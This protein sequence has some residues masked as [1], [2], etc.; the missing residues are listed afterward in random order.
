M[1]YDVNRSHLCLILKGILHPYIQYR[2]CSSPPNIVSEGGWPNLRSKSKLTVQY[3]LY[4]L[5][6]I[7]VLF[8]SLGKP[9]LKKK[10]GNIFY[11][12]V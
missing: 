11:T 6:C 3:L 9:S 10:K 4:R 1:S 5:K 7:W 12:R 2:H 8:I